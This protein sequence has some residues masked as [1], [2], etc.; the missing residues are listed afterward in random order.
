M[1]LFAADNSLMFFHDGKK[2]ILELIGATRAG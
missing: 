2:A 1:H